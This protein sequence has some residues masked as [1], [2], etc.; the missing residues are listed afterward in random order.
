M[1]LRDI[2]NGDQGMSPVEIW[3]GEA[4]E[5]YVLAV[6]EVDLS[7]FKKIAERERSRFS[8]I[9]KLQG[10]RS[11]ENHLLLKDRELQSSPIDLPMGKLFAKL[12]R[13]EK[14]VESIRPKLLPFVASLAA[15]LPGS[16]S[17]VNEATRR[18][19]SLPTVGSKSFL[20]TIGDRTVG[21]LT[22]RDQFCG[23]W[24]VPVSDVSVTATSL[25]KGIRTGV[26]MACG[27]KPTIAPICPGASARMAVAEALMNLAA[28]QLLDAPGR[29]S[30]S[31]NW[32]AN[33]KDPGQAAALFQAVEALSQ[34]CMSL[35]CV[36]PVGKDSM[37]MSSSWKDEKTGQHQTVTSPVTVVVTAYGIAEGVYNTW[38]PALRRKED[39]HG[40]ESILLYVDLARGMKRLGGSALAQTFGHIGDSAPDVPEPQTLKD[41]L[42]AVEEMHEED[43]V[44][45]YHDRSDGGLLATLAEMCFAGRCPVQVWLD[46]LCEN[47]TEDLISTLFNEELG[48]VFQIRKKD[49]LNF[50]KCFANCGPPEGM[51][52]QIGRIQPKDDKRLTIHHSQKTIFQVPISELQQVWSQTSWRMARRRDNPQCADDEYR[53]ISESFDDPGLSYRLT[54]NP[55]ELILPL[56][57]RLSSQLWLTTKPPVAILREQG[58]NGHSEMAF[59]FMQAGFTAVDVHMSDLMSSRVNLGAFI[60]IAACGGFSFGDTL[61]AGSGWAKSVLY[62]AGVKKQFQDFFRRKNTFTLGVCNGAQFLI[63]LKSLIPGAEAHWPT[64]MVRNISEQFEARS[65]MVE[66]MDNPANPSVFLNGMGG[67]KLPIAVSNGEGRAYWT[68]QPS[69]RAAAETLCTQN[70]VSLRYIDNYLRPTERY[71]ANPSGSPLGIAGITSPDSRVLAMMPHPERCLLGNSYMPEGK[72]KEWEFGPWI[73]MFRSA[74]GWVG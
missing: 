33:A 47:N 11:G 23:K 7:T 53:S 13:K 58:I 44:L 16:E 14:H 8:I 56:H 5:R 19:L 49:E 50:T 1:E 68:N 63:R 17:A 70:L 27:E 36:V 10:D 6:S 61:G 12:P 38:T 18:V 34:F 15:Y 62:H 74:R 21:G 66:V 67:S 22:V 43:F 59:A 3:S 51:I 2:D 41:F 71:P 31:A 65:S 29:V 40:E 35:D 25:T 28:A 45:A 57:K 37:S 54:F 20:I 4:Q 48:A 24:Q 52:R 69:Q 60:G 26:A 30:L 72:S 46:E 42:Y 73:R 9:G 39:D 32:M 55:N 64:S